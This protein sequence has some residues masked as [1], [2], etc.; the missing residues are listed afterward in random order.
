MENSHHG[1]GSARHSVAHESGSNGGQP[2]Q[3]KRTTPVTKRLSPYTSAV[4]RKLRLGN[5]YV[6]YETVKKIDYS[7]KFHDVEASLQLRS[8]LAQEGIGML[9]AGASKGDGPV[10]RKLTKQ[11]KNR[12]TNPKPKRC[13]NCGG[14]GHLARDCPS[15]QMR[16]QAPVKSGNSSDTTVLRVGKKILRPKKP[17]EVA[18]ISAVDA[19]NPAG[20]T[21]PVSELTEVVIESDDE[22]EPLD[23][24]TE[25]STGGQTQIE[26]PSPTAAGV[27]APNVID[28]KVDP[29][30]GKQKTI[31]MKGTRAARDS[32]KIAESLQGTL[33]DKKGE[34][35]ALRE[36]VKE[37]SGKQEE[38]EK[39][40][41]EAEEAKER[42]EKYLE[43]ARHL[44][45]NMKISFDKIKKTSLWQLYFLA[46]TT[47]LLGCV[48]TSMIADSRLLTSGEK[49]VC[50]AQVLIFVCL[51]TYFCY[52]RFKLFSRHKYTHTYRSLGLRKVSDMEVDNIDKRSDVMSLGELKHNEPVIAVFLYHRV[53]IKW[54]GP[55]PYLY[56]KKKKLHCSVELYTQLSNP[57]NIAI[58]M[59]DDIVG[60][61]IEY[62]TKQT[63]SLNIDRYE[64][65]EGRKQTIYQNTGLLVYAKFKELQERLQVCPFPRA[66]V[67]V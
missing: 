15:P 7:R 24:Q 3:P 63:H 50:N 16:N 66:P 34:I 10:N 35:D 52:L 1:H 51:V 42:Y 55:I 60:K 20:Q 32:S 17:A 65:A 8:M 19:N 58:S 59:S 44:G 61:R 37:L 23:D 39:K 28:I 12:N 62:A 36:K 43:R 57:Q 4:E 11:N 2:Y 6:Q 41:R 56:E 29:S 13:H 14:Q 47:W 21:E 46:L 9:G 54:F 67:V 49:Y 27:E 64:M 5:H 30:Q 48:V 26:L 53:E 25:E 18:S 38:K 45:G 22:D 33:A 31:K 40:E